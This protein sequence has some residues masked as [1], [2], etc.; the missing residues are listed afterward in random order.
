MAIPAWIRSSKNLQALC[1]PAE[2]RVRA[3][4]QKLLDTLGSASI[5]PPENTQNTQNTHLGNGPPD[6]K[7]TLVPTTEQTQAIEQAAA[8][9]GLTQ[10]GHKRPIPAYLQGVTGSGK[11]LVYV[12][13][14]KRL[15][16]VSPRRRC[17]TWCQRLP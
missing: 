9:L 5:G 4:L 15:W 1:E 17:F 8:S 2:T 11:T 7:I 10:A 16:Q 14:I 3:P 6:S 12:E 13:L